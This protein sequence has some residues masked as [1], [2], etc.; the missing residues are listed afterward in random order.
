MRKATVSVVCW[1]MALL[2]LV[3]TAQSNT[4]TNS[5]GQQ[6]GSRTITTAVPFLM[7]APDSR[8]GGMGEAGVALADDANA[9]HWNPAA[10]SFIDNRFGF[11]MSYSPWLRNLGIPDI[12]LAYLSG[13]FNT[14]SSGV[15][16]ASLRYFSLG[17][18]NLTNEVGDPAGEENPNEFA[19][20]VGY[21]LKIS[22][23]LSGAI[24]LRYIYSRLNS[25]GQLGGDLRPINSL[26]GDVAFYYTKDFVIRGQGNTPVQF[27]SGINISNIG[28]KVSYSPGTGARDFIPTNLRIGYAFKFFLDEYNSITLTND[29]NKLLVPSV[30]IDSTGKTT[31]GGRSD[32]PLLDGFFGSFSDAQNGLSGELAETNVSIGLEYWYRE[33]FAVRGGFFHEDPLHGNRRFI[34][35]GLGVR[36]NVFAFHVAYLVPFG[37]Q[38]PLA[39]TLRF[40]LSY[41]FESAGNQ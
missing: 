2:P 33:L 4:P 41:D 11:A 16:G 39:N 20:D 26:A 5:A 28:P 22:P 30:I 9:M 15:V 23:S 10:L 37:Q 24:S 19:F 34:N 1:L 7:V 36:Y 29:F 14:G 13:Y 12:N 40:T 38:H 8:S 17:T 27:T 6:R 25:N 32:Q 31:G 21:S 18:I 35:V 3:L